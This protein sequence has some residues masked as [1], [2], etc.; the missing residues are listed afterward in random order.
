MIVLLLMS[1][2]LLVLAKVKILIENAPHVLSKALA[3]RRIALG[4]GLNNDPLFYFSFYCYRFFV[5][6][7]FLLK[8]DN[9]T[10]CLKALY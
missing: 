8:V 1:V 3:S 4:F 9:E 6:E 2:F 10:K 7:I 5:F